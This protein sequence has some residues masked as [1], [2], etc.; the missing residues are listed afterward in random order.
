MRPD[1]GVAPFGWKLAAGTMPADDA[2]PLGIKP[3]G[4]A[5]LPGPAHNE[6]GRQSNGI[7]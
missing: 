4:T 3:P 2:V 1:A 5:V 7:A 6:I